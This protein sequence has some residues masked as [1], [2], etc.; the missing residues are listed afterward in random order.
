MKGGLNR[1]M[2][3]LLVAN[4]AARHVLGADLDEDPPPGCELRDRVERDRPP[5]ALDAV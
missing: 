2:E 3:A 1:A 4:E 5:A